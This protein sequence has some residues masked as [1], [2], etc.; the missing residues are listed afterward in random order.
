MMETAAVSGSDA[1]LD[2]WQIHNRINLYMLEAVAQEHLTGIP[3]KGRTVGEQF[4]HIYKVRL[5]WLKASLPTLLESLE[6]L[7]KERAGD[8]AAL[9]EA[10]TTSSELIVRLYAAGCEAGKIKGFKPHPTAFIGY[11]IAHESH[12]RGQIAL[13]L[14]QAGHPLDRKVAFGLWEWGSR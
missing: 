1:V 12:H 8:K 10:L 9:T 11:L 14:K 4:H 6:E 5:M 13:Y 2:T 3:A 7:P